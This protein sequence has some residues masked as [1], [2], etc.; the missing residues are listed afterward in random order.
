MISPAAAFADACR[1][2]RLLYGWD[3]RERRALFPPRALPGL[4]WRE[5]T[6]E[7]TV[8]STTVVRR[9]G[10]PPHNLALIDLYEGFRLMSRVDGLAPE[11]VRIGLRVRL[12]FDGS[13][14]PP[15]PVFVPA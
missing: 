7:G 13:Q 10:E 5:S 8:Y 1:R 2:E 11:A 15:L 14:D 4:E 9:R 3:P 12:A 6:G